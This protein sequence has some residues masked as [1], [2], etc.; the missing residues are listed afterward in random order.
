MGRLKRNKNMIN[1]KAF[2]LTELLIALGIIGAIAAMA[3]PSTINKI[4]NASLATSLKSNVAAIQQIIS[5][6][7]VLKRTKDLSDTDLATADGFYEKLNYAQKCTEKSECW[8]D[9]Y[10]TLDGLNNDT[11][12]NIPENGVKLKNGASIVIDSTIN[13]AGNNPTEIGWV[14]IDVNGPERPNIIGRDYF[15]FGIT[16]TG[17]IH[18][19]RTVNRGTCDTG[20]ECFNALMKNNWKMPNK[21]DYYNQDQEWD[22]ETG[23]C[24]NCSDY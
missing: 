11:Y 6:Q 21:A 24:L 10:K 9:S 23:E 19:Q 8:G 2:T 18:G 17:Q 14:T 1:K 20:T 22:P 16:K 15:T 3:I 4:H 13:S 5:D 12:N 7:L